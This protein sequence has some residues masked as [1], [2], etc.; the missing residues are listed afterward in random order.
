MGAGSVVGTVVG[1]VVGAV[2]A[3]VAGTVVGRVVS[4]GFLPQATSPISVTRTRSSAR[5]LFI[6]HSSL[7]EITVNHYNSPHRDLQ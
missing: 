6:V 4:A 2:V 1:S 3:S 5:Y 7:S